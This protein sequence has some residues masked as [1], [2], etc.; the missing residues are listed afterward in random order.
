VLPAWATV[1]IALGGSG[2]AAIGGFLGSY[3]TLRSAKLNIQHSQAEAWRTRLVD[4]AQTSSEAM[5]ATISAL[6]LIVQNPE[7]LSEAG[8]ETIERNLVD[9]GQSA[10]RVG[11]L[12]GDDTP[13]AEAL[14]A[15]GANLAKALN[16][17][18]ES[19]SM[20]TDARSIALREIEKIVNTADATHDAFL[21]AAHAAIRP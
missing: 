8:I 13:A 17:L 4:A 6:Y 5:T 18:R 14:N 21:R 7:R 19:L 1:A 3:F 11:L 16:N 20:H 9:A 10:I 15:A 12:F 2:I